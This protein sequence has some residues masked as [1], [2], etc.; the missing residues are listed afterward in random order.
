MDLVK[1]QKLKNKIQ[2]GSDKAPLQAMRIR[3]RDGSLEVVNPDKIIRRVERCAANLQ[4]IDYMKV[5]IKTISGLY[6]GATTSELDYLAV[7]SAANLILE[8][9]QYSKLAARLLAVIIAEEVAISGIHSFSQSIISGYNLGLISEETA[10]L[11]SK[12]AAEFNNA[13]DESRTNLF[14][15]FGLKTLH[16]RY[17]LKHPNIRQAIETP[18]YFFMRVACGLS[19][20]INEAIEFY[21]IISS[22]NYLPSTPTLFNAGTQ[23]P[24]MSSCFLL[25]SPQDSLESIYKRYWEVAALSKFSGGIGI[26]YH[27]V[28]S[29]GSPIKGTNGLSSGIIPWLK[30]LDSSVTAVNQ[31]GKRKGACCVY[32]ESWHADIEDFLEFRDNTGDQNRR[33]HQINTANWVPDLFMK[34]VEND[35][36]WSLFDPKIVPGFTDLYGE[37]FEKV[38]IEAEKKGLFTKQIKAQDLYRK[39]MKTLAETGNGWM[40]FKDA[41]NKKSNQTGEL[42]N[43]IHSSNLCTEIVEVTSEEE[44]AV[45]NLGSINLSECV[46]RETFDFK[47]LGDITRLVVPYL[48]RVIDRNLYP[49]NKAKNSNSRWRPIG[50]GIMGLQDVFFKLGLAFD[51]QEAEML[52]TKIQDEIYYNALLASTDLAERLGQAPAFKETKI[53]KGIYQFNLWGVKPS[54]EE[55]YEK[56]LE[57]IKRV[58]LRNTLLI[59][60]AP[61]ATIASIVGVYES[62]EPQVSNIFKRE[63]MSGEFT[64][65]NRYLVKELK[66]YNLWTPEIRNEIKNGEGSIQHISVIPENIKK[67]FRNVWEIPMKRIIDMAASRSPFIDQS[68]SLNLFIENPTISKLSSMYMYAWKKGL[69]TTYYLRSR[70]ATSIAKIT[71]EG[72][73]SLVEI[74]KFQEEKL[75][76]ER[77]IPKNYNDNDSSLNVCEACQ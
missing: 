30:T 10:T 36:V 71:V 65:I 47:K 64:Q 29:Q 69:K 49:V 54:D 4:D 16:E 56:L 75:E 35:E 72:K 68:Q 77:E 67:V 60:I 3:K 22:L 8:E 37:E 1:D 59:A 11:V 73:S 51:S 31:G 28:R 33:G 74:S 26:A 19:E 40:T 62:I 27:R 61:T 41:C 46:N 38:Y 17:L 12:H 32:L 18:Q 23:H 7:H 42:G 9:P 6:D 55:R 39:M 70:P 2:E 50:L 66:K 53:S 44:V 25:D 58:G 76:T 20:N 24:Q 13:I 5:A 63:T 57:R 48:D 15:Y 45:C 14:E 21:H 43:I 52:S 34:R